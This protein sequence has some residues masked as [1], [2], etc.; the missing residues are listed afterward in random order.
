MGAKVAEM[1]RTFNSKP[2][3]LNLKHTDTLAHTL[4]TCLSIVNF[5]LVTLETFKHCEEGLAAVLVEGR[6][7][8]GALCSEEV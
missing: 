1:N 3:L 4:N 8:Q 7:G 6:C 2:K 5:L